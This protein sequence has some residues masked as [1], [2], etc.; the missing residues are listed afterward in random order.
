MSF[1]WARGSKKESLCRLQL[2]REVGDV[3]IKE[4]KYVGRCKG[5]KKITTLK[6]ADLELHAP[7]IVALSPS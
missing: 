4:E 5:K 2:P 6:M 3:I 7:G 1:G